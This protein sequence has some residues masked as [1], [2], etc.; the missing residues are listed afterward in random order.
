MISEGWHWIS[1]NAGLILW[2]VFQGLLTV[3]C[4]FIWYFPGAVDDRQHY[5]P[6][7]IS[8]ADR[9]RKYFGDSGKPTDKNK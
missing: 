9:V 8:P 1:E 2:Y 3:A 6:D 5:D 4:L 7:D